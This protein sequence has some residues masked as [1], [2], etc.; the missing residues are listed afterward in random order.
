MTATTKTFIAD[1]RGP[2]GRSV[3]T[4][5]IGGDDHLRMGL[6]DGSTLDAGV[7]RG[8]QGLPGVNAIE[9]DAAVAGYVST[10]GTS[11]TKTALEAAF[12]TTLFA[13]AYGIVGDGVADDSAAFQALLT[14]AAAQ[15]ASVTLAPNSVLSIKAR[16]SI[17]SGTRLHGSWA[18]IRNDMSASTGDA[19]LWITN[20]SNVL[21]E[22]L[23][24]D[25]NK[26]AYAPATEW[27]HGITMEQASKVTIRSVFSNK[28]KGDGIYIG[29][30]VTTYCSDIVLDRV[31]CDQNHRQGISLVG[32]IGFSATNCK[33]T[34]TAGTNPQCGL[35]IEPNTADGPVSRIK[36]TACEFTGNAA[37][38]IAVAA[39]KDRTVKQ[40]DVEFIG[41]SVDGNLLGGVKLVTG[42]GIR[43]T[44][45]TI[46]GNT[47][48]GVWFS[49]SAGNTTA[50]M[51]NGVTIFGNTAKG[52]LMDTTSPGLVLNAVRAYGNT[53]AA[54]SIG[55][56]LGPVTPCADVKV[57][58]CTLGGA[59]Q[60]HGLRTQP[61]VSKLTL[62]G[63]SYPDVPNATSLND[64]IASRT[65]NEPG[66]RLA[67]TGINGGT[68]TP[69][70]GAAGALP[71]N[72]AGYMDMDI[73]GVTRRIAY[74]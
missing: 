61:N 40:G 23:T 9:N 15:G 14:N 48:H 11:A 50:V 7:A 19:L 39:W 4:A 26:A 64:D 36:F 59:T 5:A 57:I 51:F 24:I 56:D 49:A 20:A 3:Q 60:T 16:I 44:G 62:I 45:G 30:T 42:D 46:N 63:N 72:P 66:F 68:S 10:T 74:Y 18:T 47:G 41:C 6:S 31:T 71:A 55:V 17:P 43:I 2:Q 27:R 28:N 38:G 52:I 53:T 32:V 35:D 12:G 25:G 1:I 33:F 13:P 29:G 69:A 37:Y 8:A 58:G 70:G 54:A 65:R 34:R 73:N 67:V 21:I 22:Q